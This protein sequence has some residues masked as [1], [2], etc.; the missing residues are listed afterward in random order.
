MRRTPS[1]RLRIA[2]LGY[3]VRGPIGGMAWHH[4]QYVL[5]LSQLGHDVL[6]LEDS[7]DYPACYDPSTHQIGVD[8]SYGLRFA[9]DAFNKLNLND[10]W[11]YFD[12]HTQLWLGPAA[13]WAAAYCE[14]ADVLLNV[15][16]VSPIRGWH[17]NIPT[18]MLIDTD[19]V[20]TQVRHLSDPAAR[21][22]ASRHNCFFSFGE[23]IG[24][25]QSSVPDDGFQWQPT[26]QPVVID[27]WPLTQPPAGGALTTVMQWESYPAVE[28]AG[29]RY[30]LK[31]ES[32]EL[33]R[34]LPRRASVSLEIAL[35]GQPAPRQK[36]AE[37]GWRLTDPLA[38]TRDPW[39][40]Q[41]YLQQSR[42]EFSVAK[43][44]YVGSRCGWFSE[45]TACYLASGRPVIVQDT[46]FSELL[47]CGSGL[48]AFTDEESAIHAIAEL[49]FDYLAQ[50]S[51]AREIA[52]E[53]FDSN[54]V[55]ASLL[56]RALNVGCSETSAN[57][58]HTNSR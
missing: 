43:Q 49:E 53:Y 30:G 35:G 21:Q 5:G 19:P 18:R 55:L 57:A 56:E 42:G 25:G 8:P 51:A 28:F 31:S 32:F 2:V 15:S 58:L 23:L 14:Q 39:T 3:I 13:D 52:T 20:F 16:G 37:L 24:S 38:V 50:C 41:Q 46:G 40:Y 36:L 17:E 12:A 9:A 34:D 4:L 45:R 33:I 48:L 26:R 6:F 27:A 7:D 29:Q 1:E 22:R 11:G 47:P 54:N 10:R 44:G